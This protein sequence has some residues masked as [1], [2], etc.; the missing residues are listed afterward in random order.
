MIIEGTYGGV[1][2]GTAETAS[3]RIFRGIGDRAARILPPAKPLAVVRPPTHPLPQWLVVAELA[4]KSGVR[5]TDPDFNSFLYVCWFVENI[6]QGIPT[7]IESILP[8]LDWEGLADDYD[9][10]GM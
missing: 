1:L 8:Q 3:P 9:Y 2:E 6:D 10:T 4:S 5:T 7:L